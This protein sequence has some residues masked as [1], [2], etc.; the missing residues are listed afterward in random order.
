MALPTGQISMSDVNLELGYAAS[1]IISL[2]DPN[3]RLLAGVPS[4]QI[5]MQDLQGKYWNANL[6]GVQ[7][8]SAC[9]SAQSGFAVDKVNG[10][11]KLTLGVWPTDPPNCQTC[12]WHW[13]QNNGTVNEARKTAGTKPYWKMVWTIDISAMAVGSSVNTNAGQ[14][15]YTQKTATFTVTRTS[16]TSI[17]IVLYEAQPWYT[18]DTGTSISIN[19]WWDV[20]AQL[21]GGGITYDSDGNPIYTK[22]EINLSW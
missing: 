15:P 17:K 11:I 8:A 16:N 3:V 19:N 4:G 1:T 20:T 9:Y 14:W 18:G 13:L 7:S 5:S 21:G 10:A 22:G 2:N 6:T 12:D